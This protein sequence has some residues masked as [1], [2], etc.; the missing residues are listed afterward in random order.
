MHLLFDSLKV[1]HSELWTEMNHMMSVARLV[2][3]RIT[4]Q[5][6]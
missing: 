6:M 4:Q 1:Q 5:T 3:N 2:D